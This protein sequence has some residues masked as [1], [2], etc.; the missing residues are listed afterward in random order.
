[1]GRTL[2]E[3]W[4]STVSIDFATAIT[5]LSFPGAPRTWIPN[6]MLAWSSPQGIVTPQARAIVGRYVI[7]NH[8]I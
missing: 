4:E 3:F 1:M 7:P 8:R 5:R 6:G 2:D